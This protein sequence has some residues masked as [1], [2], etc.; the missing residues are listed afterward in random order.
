MSLYICH[1]CKTYHRPSS[2]PPPPSRITAASSFWMRVKITLSVRQHW[3]SHG[4]RPWKVSA[5]VKISLSVRYLMRPSMPPRSA[6][7]YIMINCNDILYIY[8]YTQKLPDVCFQKPNNSY[9]GYITS[10]QV[11][12]KYYQYFNIYH[13]IT[14]IVYLTVVE[15]QTIRFS[16][17]F[18]VFV[19]DRR[20]LST[21]FSVYAAPV[22]YAYYCHCYYTA[23]PATVRPISVTV[24]R[25]FPPPGWVVI[26]IYSL[27][28]VYNHGIRATYMCV[29]VCVHI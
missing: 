25:A 26:G 16:R 29:R 15:N 1:T 11:Y 12:R 20:L 21:I 23:E 4:G 14:Y 13:I 27:S 24:Y 9:N 18:V 3:L 7:I 17:I 8:M 5:K 2:P 19:P 28:L 22:W 6:V 10:L